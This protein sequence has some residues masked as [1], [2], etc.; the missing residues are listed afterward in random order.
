MKNRQDH[1]YAHQ[2]VATPDG[3]AVAV[4]DLGAD[5]VHFVSV[6]SSKCGE[7]KVLSNNSFTVPAGSGPR[8]IAFWPP[9]PCAEES[10]K[11]YAYLALELTNEV[12][13]F[14]YDARD[15]R[16][17]QLGEPLLA[18]PP[19]TD[20]GGTPDDG[21]ELNAGEIAVS[22]D[23]RFVYVSNRRYDADK[24][25]D[26]ISIFARDPVEGTLRWLEWTPSGGKTPRH[27]SLSNDPQAR[28]VAV[29]SETSGN[30]TIFERDPLSGK[31]S[32]TG[33][34][35]EGLDG[36]NFAGFAPF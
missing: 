15:V 8:H 20:L 13:A 7:A 18:A 25:E 5:Q 9:T 22:P 11:T 4:M 12:M 34:K 29:G 10:E 14:E 6:G 33:A 26:R 24:D 28:Y 23:G 35:A 2:V 31:L 19:G 36:I 27:F 16:L 32:K 1:S 30:M 3:A 17:R 21:A